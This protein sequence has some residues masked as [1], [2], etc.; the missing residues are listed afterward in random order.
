MFAV[1]STCTCDTAAVRIDQGCG[2]QHDRRHRHGRVLVACAV[3]A[4]PAVICALPSTI[5]VASP[6]IWPTTAEAPHGTTPARPITIA[7]LAA[8]SVA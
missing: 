1:V 5:V 2:G 6:L 4:P 7:G 8:F 3:S